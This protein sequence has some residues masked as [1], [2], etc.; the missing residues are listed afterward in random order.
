[1][2]KFAFA[3][4]VVASR[5]RGGFS[6]SAGSWNSRAFSLHREIFSPEDVEQSEPHRERRVIC[7]AYDMQMMPERAQLEFESSG[8]GLTMH[9]SADQRRHKGQTRCL[10]QRREGGRALWREEKGWKE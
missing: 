6:L 10:A 2:E 1:M 8:S 5:L 4:I 9:L 3:K 7:E